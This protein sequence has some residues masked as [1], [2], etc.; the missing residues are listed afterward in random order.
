MAPRSRDYLITFAIELASST[1]VLLLF[2]YNLIRLNDL[3]VILASAACQLYDVEQTML[4]R[5]ETVWN[6]SKVR[7]RVF[8]KQ[9]LGYGPLRFTIRNRWMIA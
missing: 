4:R 9:P 1:T 2:S 7:V 5:V 3:F 6:W 8:R